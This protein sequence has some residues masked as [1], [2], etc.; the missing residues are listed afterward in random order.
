[1]RCVECILRV[2]SQEAHK[3]QTYKNS[4]LEYAAKTGNNAVVVYDGRSLC[5]VCLTK[6]LGWEDNKPCDTK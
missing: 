3:D 5:L 2:A 6:Q 1:M 4:Q